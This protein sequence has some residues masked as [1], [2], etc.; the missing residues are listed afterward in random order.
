MHENS[1]K[2]LYIDP[3]L[4]FRSHSERLPLNVRKLSQGG[5]RRRLKS[6]EDFLFEEMWIDEFHILSNFVGMRSLHKILASNHFD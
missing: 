3:V 6:Y 4:Y 5:R 1:I 2:K